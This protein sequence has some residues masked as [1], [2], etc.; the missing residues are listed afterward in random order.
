MICGAAGYDLEREAFNTQEQLLCSLLVVV[1]AL[2]WG[3]VIGTWVSV[4]NN[5]N[6]DLKWF[7]NTMDSLNTF[8]SIHGLPSEMRTRLREYF[9]QT[10]H[11]HRGQERKHLMRLMSPQLQGEVALY[12]NQ[13]WLKNVPFLQ[14]VERELL[15]LVS[16]ITSL[17]IPL[18]CPFAHEIRLFTLNTGRRQHAARRLCSRRVS[19]TRLFLRHP[20]GR[21]IVRRE[22]ADLG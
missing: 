12:M 15:V 10:R 11:M 18:S 19:D 22:G 4:I 3:H 17:P 8:M 1:G 2:V 21:R 7:R 5:V 6:P 14:G 9:Q 16:R 20:Q 13:K